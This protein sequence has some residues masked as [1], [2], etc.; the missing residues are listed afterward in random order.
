M[1]GRPPIPGGSQ[2]RLAIKFYEEDEQR[3]YAEA[4]AALDCKGSAALREFAAVGSRTYAEL[5]PDAYAS[6]MRGE[7][8]WEE[9][10][11]E[12]AA[13]VASRMEASDHGKSRGLSFSAA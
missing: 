11:L 4:A 2:R 3:A 5:G 8:S 10:V 12:L 7:M 6:F 9:F 13:R 1:R